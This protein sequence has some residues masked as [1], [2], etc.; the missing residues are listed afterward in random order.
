MSSKAVVIAVLLAAVLSTQPL[1]PLKA[2][3]LQA[4]QSH[5]KSKANPFKPVREEKKV[6]KTDHNTYIRANP[7]GKVDTQ[8]I[9]GSTESWTLQ[10]LSNGKVMF[11]SSF[12][13]YIRAMPGNPANCDLVKKPSDATTFEV[14][15]NDDGTFSYKTFYNTY[16][17]ANPGEGGQVD[18]QTYIGSW[19]RFRPVQDSSSPIT[20]KKY[21]EEK[22]NLKTIWNTF[23]IP[24]DDQ[25]RSTILNQRNL[26]PRSTWKIEYY[27]NGR[28]AIKSVFGTYVRAYPGGDN[29]LVELRHGPITPWDTF[30][31]TTNN[32][33]SI[34]FRT[35]HNTYLRPRENERY[36][37]H[38][39]VGDWERIRLVPA[40]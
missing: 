4:Q 11:K 15:R 12:G 3:V 32:D 1:T 26:S 29:A 13:T 40:A 35:V 7:D 22:V 36:D 25:D 30:D 24:Y 33:G 16:M 27:S 37:Q 39:S 34:S 21:K 2:N 8:K 5:L 14:I 38:P 28:V 17:R 10:Y 19:E 23:A 31:I 18:V 20:A 9:P 6:I